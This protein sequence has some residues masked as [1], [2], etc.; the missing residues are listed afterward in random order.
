MVW[1]DDYLNGNES[2]IS[3]TDGKPIRRVAWLV[4][5]ITANSAQKRPYVVYGAGKYLV[6]W[7]DFSS[8]VNWNISGQLISASGGVIGGNFLICA[9][10]DGQQPTSASA[11]FDA[12]IS[13]W[14]G[15]I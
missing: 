12:R 10:T 5:A 13:W 2:S 15:S 11:A 3:G 4:V 8:G 14:L 1:P 9:P 7:N 6:L